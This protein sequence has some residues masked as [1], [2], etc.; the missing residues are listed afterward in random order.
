[1]RDKEIWE[2]N[3]KKVLKFS[4]CIPLLKWIWNEGG[5]T[6]DHFHFWANY[7]FKEHIAGKKKS[8]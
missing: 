6:Y 2:K 5:S 3:R 7:S 4:F 1:L 8:K